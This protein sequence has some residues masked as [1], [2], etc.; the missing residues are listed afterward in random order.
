MPASRAVDE[1]RMPLA[2][3]PQ[4][5]LFS[6]SCSI[7]GERLA[8]PDHHAGHAAVADDQVGAEAERHHRHLG[9]EAAQEFGEVVGVGRLEQP[10]RHCRR[11]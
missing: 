5:R 10:L 2:P 9:V 4:R 8:Q 7:F 3:P 6:S 11:S 1:T